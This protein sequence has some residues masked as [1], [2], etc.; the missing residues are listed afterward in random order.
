MCM[1][2]DFSLNVIVLT[3]ADVF[4]GEIFQTLVV[5]WCAAI[6][7]SSFC[8]SNVHV[9]HRQIFSKSRFKNM[10]SKVTI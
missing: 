9:E 5:M 4:K 7:E 2:Y 10:Q 1:L 6:N 8:D 3:I